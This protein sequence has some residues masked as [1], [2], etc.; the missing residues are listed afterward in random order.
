MSQ[1]KKHCLSLPEECASKVLLDMSH[2]EQDSTM[3]TQATDSPSTSG[4][5][6]LFRSA[7]QTM[8]EEHVL[9]MRTA[10]GELG[11]NSDLMSTD[12]I[13]NSLTILLELLLDLINS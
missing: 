1:T 8:G 12:E 2:I 5:G 9:Q 11:Y 4:S 7:N 3:L 6:Q 10:L 13:K